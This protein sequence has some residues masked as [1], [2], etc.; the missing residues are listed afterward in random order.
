MTAAKPA[1][2]IPL[3]EVCGRV[4]M[5]RSTVLLWEAEGRFPRAVRLSPTKRV[6]LEQDI[7]NWILA[8]HSSNVAVS[9]VA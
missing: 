7:D 9:E 1:R 5:Q 8:K 2:L 6:W 4:S 3:P